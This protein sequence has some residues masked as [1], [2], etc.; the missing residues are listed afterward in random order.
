MPISLRIALSSLPT[1]LPSI[2]DSGEIVA[3]GTPATL[4]EKY[5]KNY[6]HITPKDKDKLVATLKAN[7]I[8][9]TVIADVYT[10]M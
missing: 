8:D 9:F 4:K 3:K 10:V 7:N 2:I 5:A 6:L 1:S